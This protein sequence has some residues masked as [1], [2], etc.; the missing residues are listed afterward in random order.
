[1][2][3]LPRARVN[4]V[5]FTVVALISAS[6]LGFVLAKAGHAGVNEKITGTPRVAIDIYITGLKTKDLDLFKVGDESSITI[7]NQPVKPA[8]KI[9]NVERISKQVA[10]L[11]PDGKKAIAF[12]DPANPIAH[13]FTV[14]V[15]EKSEM[16]N[17]GYVISGNK[18]KVGNQIELES[19]KYRVQGVVVDIREAG[20]PREPKSAPQTKSPAK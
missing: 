12:A 6:V 3:L 9:T 14:T 2:A 10:F 17:D 13:D 16:T 15:E 18:I 4:F 8:M 7:R 20:A 1:M 5:D 11:S 19:F